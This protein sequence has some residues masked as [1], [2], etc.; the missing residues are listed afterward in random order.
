MSNEVRECDVTSVEARYLDCCL[1][2]YFQGS[3]AEEV[4][5]VPVWA[6]ITYVEAYEATK[7][8][9]HEAS[10]WYDGVAGS[11]TLVDE[12]L[13]AMFASVLA[14]DTDKPADFAK[15][16][17]EGDGDTCETC[18]LYVGL[19]AECEE[20][21]A[22]TITMLDEFGKMD[23]VRVKPNTRSEE[24]KMNN[25]QLKRR[26]CN[27]SDKAWCTHTYAICNEFGL[28]CIVYADNDQDA[29]D[30]AMDNGGLDS[31]LMDMVDY[32]EYEANGWDDSYMLLGN[33][34]E[35]VWSEYLT[36]GV[37]R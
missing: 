11:G 26:I 33:A 4:I 6:N 5:A 24:S 3:N 29:L 32:R 2:D 25:A 34:S 28:I 36:V 23:N 17:E 14:E 27:F 30:S 13:H 8:E 7:R 35:P 19:F 10:G 21:K 16:I 12:A 15:Y 37:V 1:P 20:I 22:P 31:E 9:F 18:Y